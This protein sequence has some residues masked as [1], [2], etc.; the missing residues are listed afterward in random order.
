MAANVKS[1][2]AATPERVLAKLRSGGAEADFSTLGV[3][4]VEIKAVFQTLMARG[5]IEVDG[6]D[7]RVT[8]AGL[9][10]LRKR[11]KAGALGISRLDSMELDQFGEAL[12]YV[13]LAS[14]ASPLARALQR[15][16]LERG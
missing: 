11:A 7:L 6:N 1:V 4:V 8:D 9:D 3:S 2:G 10:W 16:R 14:R 13:P 12:E 5:F 15:K